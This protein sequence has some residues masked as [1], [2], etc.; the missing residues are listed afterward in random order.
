MVGF[1]HVCVWWCWCMRCVWWVQ[2][3]CVCIYGVCVVG[4]R[5]VCVDECV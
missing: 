1:R 2:A 3:L 5:Y 4:F